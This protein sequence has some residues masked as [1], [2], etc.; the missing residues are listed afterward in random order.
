MGIRLVEP[1]LSIVKRIGDIVLAGAKVRSDGWVDTEQRTSRRE[2]EVF[3]CFRKPGHNGTS[4]KRQW[5][6][7]S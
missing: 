7:T 3:R 6:L 5:F 4:G 1:V 2:V